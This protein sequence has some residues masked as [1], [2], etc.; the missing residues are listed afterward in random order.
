MT[1]TDS[2]FIF[3]AKDLFLLSGVV[4][5]AWFW[6]LPRRQKKE[7]AVFAAVALPVIYVV[8]R[9]GAGLYFD[10]RPFVVGHFV[11]LVPHAPDNGFPSDHMLLVSAIASVIFPFSRRWSSV[12]WAVA[13]LVGAARVYVGVHHPIDVIGSAVIAIIVSAPAYFV[14]DWHMRRRAMLAQKE[15]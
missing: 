9:V 11:P 10:P 13:V 5:F 3:G 4:A 6:R 15:P 7:A 12:A 1:L 8:S 14:V 2:L